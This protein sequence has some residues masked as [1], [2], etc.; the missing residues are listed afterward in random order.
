MR[1]STITYAL[2]TPSPTPSDPSPACVWRASAVGGRV[3]YFGLGATQAGAVLDL[4][5][6]AELEA[7]RIESECHEELKRLATVSLPCAAKSM[8]KGRRTRRST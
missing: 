8:R 3:A 4:Q 5:R 2:V 1:D 7:R 6:G